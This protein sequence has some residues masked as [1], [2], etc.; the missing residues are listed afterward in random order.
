[1]TSE[2]FITLGKLTALISFIIGTVI[3]GGYFLTSNSDSLFIGYGFIVV[4]GIT[5]LIIL[6]AIIF[7]RCQRPYLLCVL[8]FIFYFSYFGQFLIR[9]TGSSP[10]FQF[11]STNQ[12][13]IRRCACARTSKIRRCYFLRIWLKSD[14]AVKSQ[15]C[16]FQIRSV[17]KFQI[18]FSRQ[19]CFWNF[20]L[21]NEKKNFDFHFAKFPHIFKG[22]I[23]RFLNFGEIF[24]DMVA[25][26]WC[27]NSCG[28]KHLK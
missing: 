2:K 13:Q 15:I 25:N 21:K 7:T 3:F 16:R 14:I 23:L 5:N 6:I 8:Y 11:Y 22:Q 4:A 12:A 17:F 24:F 27:K 9:A 19:T 1:M 20:I 10:T 18:S 26:V 28:G